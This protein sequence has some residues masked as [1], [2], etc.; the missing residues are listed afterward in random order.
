LEELYL[1][2]LNDEFYSEVAETPEETRKLLE[3][4]WEYTNCEF[5]GVK[6]FRKRK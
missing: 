2:E 5:D 1:G 6:I 4:G 3:A